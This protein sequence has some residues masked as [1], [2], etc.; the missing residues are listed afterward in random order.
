MAELRSVA[1]GSEQVAHIRGFVHPGMGRDQYL[2]QG[3]YI[4]TSLMVFCNSLI[5]FMYGLKRKDETEYNGMESYIDAEIKNESVNWIP[6]GRAM[7]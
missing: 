2:D 4:S 5:F 1:P 7:C 6:I 3:I